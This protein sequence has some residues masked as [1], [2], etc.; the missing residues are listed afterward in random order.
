MENILFLIIGVVAGALVAWII[1]KLLVEKNMVA[2]D[3]YAKLENELMQVVAA[4]KFAQ[5]KIADQQKTITSN[6]TVVKQLSEEKEH[7]QINLSSVKT[8]LDKLDIDYTEVKSK[9]ELQNN[10]NTELK[11]Y[12]LKVRGEN[13]VLKE[14]NNTIKKE[15]E[16]LGEKYTAQFKNLANEILEDKSKRFTEENQKN[17]RL[18]LDPLGIDLKE[19]K[20]KVEETYEKENKQRFSLEEKIKDLVSLNKQISEEANNLTK[21][22]KGQRKTQGD[23]GEMILENIL[24]QSGLSEGREYVKQEFLRDEAG[25]TLFNDENQKMQPDFVIKYPDK[26]EIIIDSKV[27]LSA[28]ERYSS[29]D[30]EL[31]QKVALDAHLA[32]VKKHIDELDRRN[33]QQFSKSLDFVMMFIP[34][35]PAYML[36]MQ[37]DLDLWNYAYRKKVLLISP[38][39]LIAAVK[40]LAELWKKDEQNKNALAIADR[41][42]QLYDKFV[43]FVENLQSIGDS[44][45]RSQKSYDEAMK[46]LKEGSGNLIGQAEK[47]RRLGVQ[48][49]KTLPGVILND[50]EGD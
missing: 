43:G 6:E 9:F 8:T 49:K 28:Y 23:W 3:A 24:Q 46:Q 42:A 1:R 13:D 10:Q 39:N 44:I 29:S 38:T 50:A 20:K 14:K 16:D 12:I 34:I 7:L 27:S 45:G 30:D 19:F 33:Y 25:N 5:E 32:A 48:G 47:L 17:I 15:I 36:A 37:K 40:L 18:I 4:Q 22:L 35:E 2:R 26:R 21:A 41:G 11:E 31:E